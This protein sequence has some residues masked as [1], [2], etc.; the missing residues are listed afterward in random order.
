MEEPTKWLALLPWVEYLYNTIKHSVIK[1]TPFKVVYGRPPPTLIP[2]E[3]Q[4]TNNEMVDNLLKQCDKALIFLRKNATKNAELNETI[5]R[6][7][8]PRYD[9]TSE[10]IGFG[11]TVTL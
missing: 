6:C 3:S 8:T 10:R 11:K 1:T 7:K 2:Y 4:T 5:G 9:I